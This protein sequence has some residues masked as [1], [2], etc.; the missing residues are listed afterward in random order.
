[1]LLSLSSAVVGGHGV[2]AP[3]MSC[4]P[5]DGLR[6]RSYVASD[7]A[8]KAIALYRTCLQ[9]IGVGE[10]LFKNK[11]GMKFRICNR[12]SQFASQLK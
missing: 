2:R 7:L 5:L 1:M 11:S 8:C 12:S 9:K 10:V 6:G 3:A 4:M